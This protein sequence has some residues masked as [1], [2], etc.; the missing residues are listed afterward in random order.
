AFRTI[1]AALDV[2]PPEAVIRIAPGTYEEPLWITRPVTLEGAG[3]KETKLTYHWFGLDEVSKPE[4]PLPPEFR[5]RFDELTKKLQTTSGDAYAETLGT[6]IKEFGPKRTLTVENTRGVV[7][8][9]LQVSMWGKVSAAG[10]TVAPM[11][12]VDNGGI[13]VENCALAGSPV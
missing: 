1:Q 11:L 12:L 2:A 6:L 4:F 3:W 5:E 9:G 13:A 10:F 8:R 7:V